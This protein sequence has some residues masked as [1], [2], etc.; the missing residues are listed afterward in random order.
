MS[1]RPTPLVLLAALGLVAG[2]GDSTITQPSVSTYPVEGKI[3]LPDGKPL[4]EGEVRFLP[5][6]PEVGREAAGKIKPDGTFT[7][8]TYKP[9]DGAAEGE[10]NVS[11]DSEQSVPD[12]SSKTK[13]RLVLQPK[14]RDGGGGLKATIKAGKNDL[15][16][17]QLD[18]KAYVPDEKKAA[19]DFR[20]D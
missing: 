16:P 6:K 7:L 13:T 8:T 15:P 12:P 9:D 1:I 3:L 5:V 20:R 19:D 4:T 17:F 18:T 14:Y 11:I 2:C 10:Y